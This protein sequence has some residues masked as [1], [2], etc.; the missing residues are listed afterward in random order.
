MYFKMEIMQLFIIHITK[1][2]NEK[3]TGI[4]VVGMNK[5]AMSSRDDLAR[6]L[7]YSR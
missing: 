2:Y 4:V 5:R 1:Y 7:R 6:H 3:N